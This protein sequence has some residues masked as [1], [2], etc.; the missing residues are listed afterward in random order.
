MVRATDSGAAAAT[1]AEPVK[2]LDVLIESE[3]GV[4][5]D[6]LQQHLARGEWEAA[7]NETR[8]LLCVLA[9]EGAAKRKW[10]YF[11]EV[12][13]IPGKDLLTIDRL[14][15]TYSA[16]R[17]GYSVQRRLWKALDKRWKPFFLKIDWTYGVNSSFRKF[18]MEFKWESEA[19]VGHLP[20]TN[21]LRGTQLFE[22]L[23]MHPAFT[24]FDKEQEMPEDSKLPDFSSKGSGDS[25]S[26]SSESGNATKPGG[27]SSVFDEDFNS[28]DFGF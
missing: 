7:D 20:L 16:D 17:F 5:Y 27:F 28:A 8:R 6:L 15:R 19:A 23:L 11:T 14:W 18:P 2:L 9:G 25:S 13:F 24:V 3:V 21:C 1:E 10:V 12:Q 26:Q 4:S 22:Y